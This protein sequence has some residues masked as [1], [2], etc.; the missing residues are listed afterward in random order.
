MVVEPVDQ[1]YFK[2]GR[3]QVPDKLN[4]GKPAADEDNFFQGGGVLYCETF[5]IGRGDGTIAKNCKS[6]DHIFQFSYVACP[7]DLL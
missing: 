1:Q 4:P 3:I 2:Q 7:A 5:Y 6:L